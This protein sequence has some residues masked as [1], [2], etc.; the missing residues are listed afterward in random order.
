MY[1][2]KTK[3]TREFRTG[4]YGDRDS[5]T[6]ARMMKGKHPRPTDP[7][8]EKVWERT[9]LLARW[10]KPTADRPRCP[11]TGDPDKPKALHCPS[12]TTQENENG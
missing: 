9:C 12:T 3:I 7:P 1:R 11:V 6:A 5:V 8:P 10:P 4:D 2:P